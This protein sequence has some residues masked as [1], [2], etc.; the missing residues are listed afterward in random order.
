[1]KFKQYLNESV[2]VD[3]AIDMIKKKCAP[4]YK[5]FT[6]FPFEGFLYSGRRSNSSDIIE[7]P[8][9]T[10]RRPMDT[11]I[12]ISAELD[13]MFYK[14]FKVKPRSSSLFCIADERD[15]A[16]YGTP[17]VIFPVGQ[18]K[19]IYSD[20]VGDL[21][22]ETQKRDIKYLWHKDYPKAIKEM[23]KMVNTYKDGN[24]KGAIKSENEVMLLAKSYIGFNANLYAYDFMEIFDK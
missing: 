24:I 11:K 2:S 1:M 5:D 10:D 8:I 13:D 6:R 23:Q 21:Y 7:K 19:L 16:T 15:A 17:Y 18:Y 12:D 14:K 20:R 9:R 3:Q 22:T 4:F